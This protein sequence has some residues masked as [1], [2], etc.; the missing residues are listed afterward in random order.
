MKQWYVKGLRKGE[1]VTRCILGVFKNCY[2]F[3]AGSSCKQVMNS[4]NAKLLNWFFKDVPI[5]K[6]TRP[7]TAFLSFFVS[8]CSFF[9][10]KW[11]DQQQHHSRFTSL[12]AHFIVATRPYNSRMELFIPYPCYKFPNLPLTFVMSSSTNDNGIYDA[13]T[14]TFESKKKRG[15]R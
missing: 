10:R 9:R 1:A 12:S 7:T 6:K 15:G 13:A 8:S 3:R 4:K 2:V 14:W 5:S 11:H